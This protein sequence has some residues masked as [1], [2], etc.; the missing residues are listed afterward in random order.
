MY[1]YEPFYWDVL[2]GEYTINL[3]YYNP[4]DDSIVSY[5]EENITISDDTY[6]WIR[7][8]D[9]RDIIIEK[10][11]NSDYEKGLFSLYFDFDMTDSVDIILK[12]LASLEYWEDPDEAEILRTNL[13]RLSEDKIKK[14]LESRD[15]NY[16]MWAMGELM[17]YRG[18]EFMIPVMDILVSKMGPGDVS[19]IMYLLFDVVSPTEW[20]DAERYID[21]SDEIESRLV[22]GTLSLIE[23]EENIEVI[24]Q[25]ISAADDGLVDS[26]ITEEKIIKHIDIDALL[27]KIEKEESLDSIIN[28]VEEIRDISEEVGVNIIDRLP[29]EIKDKLES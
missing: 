4:V 24:G 5:N 7:G 27:K 15:I 13:L 18:I 14:D 9:L 10:S 22:N 3:T 6:Y 23:K 11:G 17:E 26:E 20:E 12:T 29:S 2:A 21:V 19:D 28:C 8:Y 25:I 1:P 16:V